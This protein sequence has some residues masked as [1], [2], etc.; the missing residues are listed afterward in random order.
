MLEWD[1][2]DGGRVGVGSAII[3]CRIVFCV[4]SYPATTRTLFAVVMMA[5]TNE[6]QR[7]AT[8]PPTPTFILFSSFL[9]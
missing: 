9:K 6:Q 8:S 2:D 1:V 4:S 7:K 5:A 3:L